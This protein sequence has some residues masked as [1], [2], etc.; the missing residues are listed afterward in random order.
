MYSI[1]SQQKKTEAVVAAQGKQC[2]E[3]NFR[4]ACLLVYG[5]G[6]WRTITMHGKQGRLAGFEYSKN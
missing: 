4:L 6:R 2:Y 5:F 1:T 3:V